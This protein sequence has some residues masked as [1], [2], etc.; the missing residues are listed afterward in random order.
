MQIILVGCGAVGTTII[1]QLSKEDHNITVI[2]L[3]AENLKDVV[4][5]YDV[6]GIV[7]NG[8]SYTTMKEAGIEGADLM[9]AV[10][11]DDELNLLSCLIAKKAGNCNTIARVRNPVYKQEVDY[12]KEEQGL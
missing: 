1:D 4:D 10:T 9:I 11:Q 2:D 7:G 12:I 5:S 3:D 8:A 6:M